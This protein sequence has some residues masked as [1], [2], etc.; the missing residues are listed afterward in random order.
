M[1]GTSFSV[2][3]LVAA[4]LVGA[5]SK[6]GV[7]DLLSGRFWL[8][9]S[10]TGSV[11]LANGSSAKVDLRL[12][13]KGAQG[14]TL[15]VV[16]VGDQTLLLDRRS[17]DVSRLDVANLTVA[18]SQSLPDAHDVSLLTIG[19]R[20]VVVDP[21]GSVAVVNPTT[22]ETLS[23]LQLGQRLT[24]GV[25]AP[26]G[27]IWVGEPTAGVVVPLTMT[28]D[29]QLRSAK[30]V[31][32]GADEG[33]E[34]SLV[35]DKPT[36]VSAG[37]R[38]II[39]IVGSTPSPSV[40]FPL[41]IGDTVVVPPKVIG[42]LLPISVNRAGQL[43]LVNGSDVRP[44]DLGLQGKELGGP[45][46]FDGKV[47]VPNYTDGRLVV[48][49]P[50][51][52]YAN[53]PGVNIAANARFSL[54]ED[55]GRLWVDDPTG[56]EAFV[57]GQGGTGF[58]QIDKSVP[59]VP[60]NDRPTTS[61]PKPP[62]LFPATTLPKTQPPVTQGGSGPSTIA[63]RSV[64]TTIPPS[65]PGAPTTVAASGGN[66]TAVVSWGP[67][68]A[69]GA[70]IQ[71][72]DVSWTVSGKGGTPGQSTVPGGS[73]QTTVGS[74][75]NGDTYLFTVV[76]KNNVGTGPGAVSPPVTPSATVPSPPGPP[77][78][79][80]NADGSIDLVWSAANGQGH[81]IQ[82]YDVTA[83]SSGAK[84]SLVAAKV[85]GIAAHVTAADGLVLGTS[86]T[87]TVIATND[88]NNASM[89]SSP[90]NAVTPYTPASAPGS[91]TSKASGTDIQVNWQQP[92]LNGGTLVSYAVASDNGLS[93]Q[94]ISSG[95]SAT[96][97]GLTPGTSYTFTITG[98][99]TANGKTVT[100]AK[101]TTPATAVGIAPT[102]SNLSASPSGDRQIAVSFKV[103][104]HNSGAV[105][106]KVILNGT[107]AWQ[108]GCANP[109]TPTIGGLAY[110]TDYDVYATADN[111]FG[112]SNASNHVGVR[113]ND[114]PPSV[115]VS[116][117][118]VGTSPVGTCTTASAGCHWVH[119][120]L[121]NFAANASVRVGCSDSGGEF[122]SYTTTT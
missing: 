122:Y 5:Q 91:P 51:G 102:V 41:G 19:D 54:M 56:T 95:T 15:E 67:A 100:G 17:G 121:R 20:L 34:L 90:S 85:T 4:L 32:V 64:A 76:A 62:V 83:T 92:A 10:P 80:A 13:I 12:T 96:F 3:F 71:E 36:V 1:I 99:T 27:T 89:P 21:R 24:R 120:A 33:M 55:G 38:A 115:T 78:A 110:A 112:S 104:G 53:A 22:L 49:E 103:D 114:P 52:T 2:F 25:I 11:M 61:V 28:A 74:L 47:Y 73:G 9:N 82:G 87:F 46:P 16:R 94:T 63:P 45:I 7:I 43:V 111:S 101:A 31:D 58:R 88:L 23:T 117:A 59:D 69:N 42:A 119:V 106:C 81:P 44:V 75:T 116:K 72:Y 37:K 84:G 6:G 118:G 98:V 65:A 97:S 8:T 77:T 50:S 48:V 86:Y 30:P 14:A 40:P 60:T 39:T 26:N 108:G 29:G 66:A 107:L 18:N 70:A 93:P 109:A 57:L 79:T 105:T 68:S 113:T 35:D